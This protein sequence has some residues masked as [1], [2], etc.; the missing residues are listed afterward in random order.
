MV[1][2]VVRLNAST[3]Y[4]AGV[5][6][7]KGTNKISAEDKDKIQKDKYGKLLISKNIL[8]FEEIKLKKKGLW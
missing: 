4:I 1:T 7:Y 8:S 3:Q 5:K 2:Y 6:V